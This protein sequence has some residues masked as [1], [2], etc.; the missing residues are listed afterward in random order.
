MKESLKFWA[1]L[2]NDNIGESSTRFNIN[3]D[4][5][6]YDVDFILKY[7]TPESKILDIGSGTG[8]IINQLYKHVQHITA[9]EP[10]L[11]FTQ[12]I[13]N[14]EN[15]EIV[16][17]TVDEFEIIDECYDL[18]TF[19]GVIQYLNEEESNKVYEKYYKTLKTGG[20][21]IV[22]HQFG[23]TED[24]FV[25]GFSKELNREYVSLY[26]HIDKEVTMLKN[27]SFKNIEVIDIYPPEYNRW[28]NTHFYAIVAE[29]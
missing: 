27:N 18:L 20:K 28:S 21:I 5:T 14:I 16:N 9:V 4:I 11:N 17:V 3:K 10:F 6:S 15:I 1:K 19:F 7:V 24:V 29:K 13:K 22:K 25:S 12:Y 26:R 2:A 8:I 23:I